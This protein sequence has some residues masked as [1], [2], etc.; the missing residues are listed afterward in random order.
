VNV[1]DLEQLGAWLRVLV[2]GL[3]VRVHYE[4][5]KVLRALPGFDPSRPWP[6]LIAGAL[7]LRGL[8]VR[9]DGSWAVEGERGFRA[10][11]NQQLDSWRER[12]ARQMIEAMRHG[13]S[14]DPVVSAQRELSLGLRALS[15]PRVPLATDEGPDGDV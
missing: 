6:R 8:A 5:P 11:P 7:G 2:P 3:A 4:M 12:A 10:A 15:M 1:S 14:N 13:D 9:S